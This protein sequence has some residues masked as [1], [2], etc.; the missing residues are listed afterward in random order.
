MKEFNKEYLIISILPISMIALAFILSRPI[1]ILIGL[2]DIIKANN[3]LVSD[4]F[5]IANIGSAF[6]NSG[7]I[8]IL[9]IFLLYKM[10][11]KLNGLLITAI[12]LILSFGFMG[13]NI[14]NIIPF[15][16][17]AY[18][19][20][21]VFNKK[22]KSL[23]AIAMM[24]TT[25]APL[26]SAL[27]IYVG[28]SMAIIIAFLLPEVT[29]H[30]IH[31]HS[32][33]NLYNTGLTGGMLGILIY[34]IIKTFGISFDLNR[35]YYMNFNYIIFIFFLLYFIFLLV[36]SYMKIRKTIKT[37]I[38][39][40][41]KHTGRL[42]TDFVQKDGFYI[43]IFNMGLLGIIS[44][45]IIYYFGIINGPI[46]CSMLTVVG[47][48][49]FGKHIKNILPVM[50]GVII[51]NYV[52]HIE[53]ST[54]LLVMT[55]FFSTTLAPLAG[56]FGILVGVV[57]GILHYVVAIQIG[58]IHGGLNLYNNGLAAGIVTSILLPI[59]QSLKEVNFFGGKKEKTGKNG[60]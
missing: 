18:V 31:I 47:F 10:K 19:N 13:K 38:K 52:F 41:C 8:T 39:K 29:K 30:M 45:V 33:Y 23:I 20:S 7:I 12:F 27:N 35:E 6:F 53:L 58:D 9:N 4:Y 28:F 54:T 1:D 17:G 43:S 32:G 42:V 5:V 25:L 50:F 14:I 21:I 24:S 55:I 46:I 44:L 51:A 37:D 16:I 56:K 48:G 59:I 34:S 2:V 15:Y 3:I 57:A 36:I 22:F 49:G 26:V 60:R 11:L 40:L